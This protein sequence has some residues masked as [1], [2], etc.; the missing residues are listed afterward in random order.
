MAQIGFRPTAAVLGAAILGVTMGGIA[1]AQRPYEAAAIQHY[2]CLRQEIS[3]LSADMSAKRA[4]LQNIDRRVA[5]LT[6]RLRRERGRINVNNPNAVEHFKALLHQRD[7]AYRASVGAVWK[8]TRAAVAR[9]DAAVRE[10]NTEDAHRLWDPVLLRHV[11]ATL[12]CPG[13]GYAAPGGYPPPGYAPRPSNYAQPY[14]GYPPPAYGPAS[15]YPPP[16]YPPP[17]YPGPR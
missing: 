16:E 15:G 9:Y 3:R 2:L 14:A 17:P 5:E 6:A 1:H 4:R 12:T 8:A 13:S 11:E 7:A 10:Y